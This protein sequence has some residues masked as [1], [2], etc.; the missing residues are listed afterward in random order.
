M[1]YISRMIE[2]F[3]P[4]TSDLLCKYG[5]C[6]TDDDVEEVIYSGTLETAVLGYGIEIKGVDVVTLNGVSAIRDIEVYQDSRYYKPIQ[7]KTKM[8]RGVDVVTFRD[9]IVRFRINRKIFKG[10][11]RLRLSDYAKRMHWST[12]ADSIGSMLI[13]VLDDNFEIY[14]NIRDRNSHGTILDVR[15]VTNPALIDQIYGDFIDNDMLDQWDWHKRI[16]D[17]QERI[18]FWKCQYCICRGEDE[19]DSFHL[20]LALTERFEENCI[21]LASAYKPEFEKVAR[22]DIH[23][24]LRFFS[25]RLFDDFVALMRSRKEKPFSLDDYECLRGSCINVLDLISDN[26]P[27]LCAKQFRNFIKYMHVPDDIRR[28]Y[29]D[30]CNNAARAAVDLAKAHNIF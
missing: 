13:F 23:L 14:G 27:N 26:V 18:D 4:G 19:T 21:V 7:A 17:T 6:D 20:Q 15:E 2:E 9:E 22:Y 16:I 25:Q 29:I 5:V 24:L 8:L 1:L 30:V 12:Y 3:M 10:P 11:L 28:L